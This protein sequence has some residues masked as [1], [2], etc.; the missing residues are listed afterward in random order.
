VAASLDSPRDAVVPTFALRHAGISFNSS[1]IKTDGNE[2]AG[3]IDKGPMST[4]SASR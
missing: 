4:M 2:T 3:Q 1:M